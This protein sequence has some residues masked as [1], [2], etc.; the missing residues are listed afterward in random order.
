MESTGYTSYAS[1]MEEKLR[2]KKTQGAINDSL[3][4]AIKLCRY[5]HNRGDTY[6]TTGLGFVHLLGL[7]VEMNLTRAVEFLQS[8]AAR[9]NPEG[10]NI[11]NTLL[12]YI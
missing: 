11:Y 10:W 4:G 8:A 9:Q 3:Q 12:A 6:G 2:V 5:A 7:G 1:F